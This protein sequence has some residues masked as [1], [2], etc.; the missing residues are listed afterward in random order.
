MKPLRL[1]ALALAAGTLAA[2]AAP[3]LGP[4]VMPPAAKAATLETFRAPGVETSA[5]NLS[6]PEPGVVEALKSANAQS[7]SKRLEVGIGRAVPEAQLASAAARWIAIGGGAVARWRVRSEA[8]QSLR[9]A[10]R[11]SSW[12]AEAELRFAGNAESIVYAVTGASMAHTGGAYW[13]PVLEGDT[14]TVEVFVPRGSPLPDLD[15]AQVSHLFVSFADPKA[16]LSAK[17]SQP[18]QVNLICRSA[19]E[20]ALAEAARS[21]ARITFTT[22]GGNSVLCTGTLLNSNAAALTPYLATAGHCIG[23]PSEAASITTRWFYE[24]SSCTGT[25]INPDSTQVAGGAALLYANAS[26]DFALVRLNATPPANAVFAGWDAA[27][28]NPGEPATGIHHPDGD[29]KKVSLGT[30][31]GVGQSSVAEGTGFRIQWAG[32]TTGFTEPGSSGSGIFTGSSVAGYRFRGTLQGGPIGAC[33]DPASRLYDYY[34]RFDLAFPFIAQWL[35]PSTSPGLGQNALANAGFES[36]FSS[37]TQAVSAGNS[38]VITNDPSTAR[39]GGWYAWLGG[40]NALTDSLHQNIAVP[41]GSARLQFWYRISSEETSVTRAFDILTVSIADASSGATLRELGTLSNLDR[42]TGWVQSPVYDVST[43][44]N[45][46]VRVVFR[47]VTDNSLVTSFRIDDVTVNGTPSAVP[48]GNHT[49]LWLTPEEAGWGL[50]VTHQ[51]DLVFATLFTYASNGTPLWLVTSSGLRQEGA[52]TFMGDL[53][54]TTGP[55]FN[56]MPFTPIGP[57]NSTRVGSLTVDYNGSTAL[58]GYD[59][60]DVYVSKVIQKHVFRPGAGCTSTTGSRANATNYQDLW[61]KADEAGWGLNI[62]HQGDV[63]FATLFTY[64][65]NGQGLWLVMSSG[66]RQADGSYLGDLY[67]TSGPAFNATPFTPITFPQNYTL[68]GTMRLRFQDG[69]RG[70]LEYSVNGTQV[71]KAISRFVFA[72]PVPLCGQ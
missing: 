35:S 38:V 54:R 72:S 67:R 25:A 3:S 43:F 39:S 55:P 12:P 59:V 33:T 30:A 63:I 20:P 17:A 46:T 51:G 23:A 57:S 22:T 11:A 42:T 60:D 64:G 29:P 9:V 5:V 7:T 70:T 31:A 37:W 34:S 58:L 19:T 24:T 27:R 65:S 45:R 28:L 4:A 1:L 36:G 10:L 26:E 68:V 66:E 61:L 47:S 62:T 52:A 40:V 69:E 16:D 21:V 13:S 48:Q 56:A 6:A 50:N 44:G 53:Y 71:V 8:A 15:V 14:A 2:H 49:A 32:A 41:A 18:C